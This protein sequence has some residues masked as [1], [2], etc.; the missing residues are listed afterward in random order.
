MKRKIAV[1]ITAMMMLV[2][3]LTACGGSKADPV[4]GKWNAAKIKAVGMEISL[5][6][7][8]EQTGQD[9]S[10]SLEFKADGKLSAEAMGQTSEGEWKAKDGGKYDVTLDGETEEITFEEGNIIMDFEG[11]LLIF[12]KEEAEK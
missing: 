4:E 7:F 12:E 10:I 1:I 11:N 5:D 8:A 6:E 3:A 2:L 9:F